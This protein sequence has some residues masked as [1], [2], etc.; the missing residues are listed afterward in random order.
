MDSFLSDSRAKRAKKT[1]KSFQKK[2]KGKE[3]NPSSSFNQSLPFEFPIFSFRC[4]CCSCEISR[5]W[6]C[7]VTDGRKPSLKVLFS[8]LFL[9]FFLLFPDLSFRFRLDRSQWSD[10]DQVSDNSFTFRTTTAR[11]FP[12]LAWHLLRTKK[13]LWRSHVCIINWDGIVKWNQMGWSAVEVKSNIIQWHD[14]SL[15]ALG[16]DVQ[17][18]LSSRQATAPQ[19]LAL[20]LSLLS[21]LSALSSFLCLCSGFNWCKL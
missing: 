18:L 20:L 3:R 11:A 17:E 16:V 15:I 8:F 10:Q 6:V 5:L 19:G 13:Y 12:G 9:S 14:G 1:R 7:E 21:S 2:K 4:V